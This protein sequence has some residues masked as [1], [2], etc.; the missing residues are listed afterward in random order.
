MQSGKKNCELSLL[1]IQFS[2]RPQYK[3]YAAVW[4]F[5]LWEY[6]V[7]PSQRLIR[8]SLM[9]ELLSYEYEKQNLVFSH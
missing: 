4:Y 2:L 5:A 7:V 1:L 6:S 8:V 9:Y 3:S